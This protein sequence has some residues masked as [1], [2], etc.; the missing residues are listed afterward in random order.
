MFGFKLHLASQM[1]CLWR[2][3]PF[4]V[5]DL[6]EQENFIGKMTHT[7]IVDE[8]FAPVTNVDRTEYTAIGV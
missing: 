5:G 1:W 6:A 2:F 3:L 8:V 4:L 7:N